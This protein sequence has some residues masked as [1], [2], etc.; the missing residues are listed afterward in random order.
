MT[1]P[2]V[3]TVVNQIFRIKYTTGTGTAFIY[4]NKNGSAFLTAAHNLKNAQKGDNVL[5]DHSKGWVFLREHILDVG[6]F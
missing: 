6:I 3:S 4:R 1:R 2:L 5:F